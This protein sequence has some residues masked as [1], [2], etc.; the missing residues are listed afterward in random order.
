MQKIIW[1][2]V[3]AGVVV[4]SGFWWSK[5]TTTISTHT[6]TVIADSGCSK[7]DVVPNCDVTSP[8]D[9][10]EVI[11]LSPVYEPKFTENE[12]PLAEFDPM[13]FVEEYGV[14]MPFPLKDY[15]RMPLIPATEEESE[16]FFV[17][18]L[19]MPAIKC[20]ELP[21][22]SVCDDEACCPVQVFFAKLKAGCVKVVFGEGDA[23][24]HCVE[25]PKCTATGCEFPK[26]QNKAA[27]QTEEESSPVYEKLPMPKH[28]ADPNTILPVKRNKIDTMEVR[29]TDVPLFSPYTF[30]Y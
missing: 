7:C 11:D 12:P 2:F 13:R 21:M 22:P 23:C 28:L 9:I 19:P 24:P 14:P 8:V 25:C 30:P 26:K 5:R 1:G 17:E 16:G 3:I 4:G 10:V 29:P 6:P 27:V 15:A 20:E 18:V